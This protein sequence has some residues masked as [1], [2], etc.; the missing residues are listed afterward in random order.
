MV[1][2]LTAL[3]HNLINVSLQIE[4]FWMSWQ[5]EGNFAKVFNLGWGI[6]VMM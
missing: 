2:W 1:N 5:R 4:Y 6:G 3:Q